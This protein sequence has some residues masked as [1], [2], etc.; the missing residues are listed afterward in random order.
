MPLVFSA[1]IESWNCRLPMSSVPATEIKTRADSHGNGH[2][3][4]LATVIALRPSDPTHVRYRGTVR[5]VYGVIPANH[6]GH[7]H[8]LLRYK[9]GCAPEYAHQTAVGV[10]GQ[11]HIIGV[12]VRADHVRPV[13]VIHVSPR[14][15]RGRPKLRRR[16]EA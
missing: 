5:R 12:I 11:A 4:A 16:R 3:P 6:Q 15:R 2:I 10:R 14:G 1:A 8:Y 7:K 9:R 13:R